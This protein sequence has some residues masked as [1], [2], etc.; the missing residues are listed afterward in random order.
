MR[1]IIWAFAITS[2]SLCVRERAG[3]SLGCPSSSSSIE[4]DDGTF[5]R[6]NG[7]V[8]PL[9]LDERWCPTLIPPLSSPVLLRLPPDCRRGTAKISALNMFAGTGLRPSP[10]KMKK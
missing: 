1:P 9:T 7:T 4:L 6:N 5:G 8:P 10:P 3:N 2:Y